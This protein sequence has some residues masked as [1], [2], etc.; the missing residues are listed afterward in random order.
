[1]NLTG[2]VVA[3][4]A[5][6]AI[7]AGKN[8]LV[9]KGKQTLTN[10]L[11]VKGGELFF[12]RK[13]GE[14]G[15]LDGNKVD[16]RGIP[17]YVAPRPTGIVKLFCGGSVIDG[18]NLNDLLRDQ[19][20]KKFHE[21]IEGACLQKA[22]LPEV[23]R[24]EDGEVKERNAPDAEPA[25]D[26]GEGMP[27]AGPSPEDAKVS[28]TVNRPIKI[29]DFRSMVT[30][31]DANM[32]RA[33]NRGYVRFVKTDGGEGVKLGK[34][35]NVFDKLMSW[36][37][38]VTK[39]HNRQM[40][41]LFAE[42]MLAD[43]GGLDCVGNAAADNSAYGS[44][45]ANTLS[46]IRTTILNS[47]D[48]GAM[49]KRSDMRKCFDLYDSIFGQESLLKIADSFLGE[50]LDQCQFVDGSG[51]KP[52]LET[53][54]KEYGKY[55]PEG[56]R[57][58]GELK[59]LLTDKEVKDGKSLKLMMAAIADAFGQMNSVW[60]QDKA[61]KGYLDTLAKDPMSA[62][63]LKGNEKQL[64]RLRGALLRR[65]PADGKVASVDGETLNLFFDK[66]FPVLEK[67]ARR[68]FMEN[69]DCD[70]QKFAEVKESRADNPG[71]LETLLKD[72]GGN[73]DKLSFA[74]EMFARRLSLEGIAEALNDF[75]SSMRERL[76]PNN[77]KDL[78]PI[79][80]VI[81]CKQEDKQTLKAKLESHIRESGNAD[82]EDQTTRELTGQIEVIDK[83]IAWLNE[84]KQ[85]FG[86]DGS[87]ELSED[88][89][90]TMS[91]GA[92][93]DDTLAEDGSPAR[94]RA[95][96]PEALRKVVE[97]GVKSLDETFQCNYAIQ[98]YLRNDKRYENVADEIDLD[99][100]AIMRKITEAFD[101]N[102]ARALVPNVRNEDD[103]GMND[104]IVKISDFLL[105]D[106][107]LSGL[108]NNEVERTDMNPEASPVNAVRTSL[109]T[110]IN[111]MM[112]AVVNKAIDR[113]L[114][115]NTRFAD[116]I[117][118][119]KS[120]IEVVVDQLTALFEKVK[121]G[122]LNGIAKFA[123]DAKLFAMKGA[124]D[125][126]ESV[127]KANQY[128]ENVQREIRLKMLVPFIEEDISD[129]LVETDVKKFAAA[130]QARLELRVQE[131]LASLLSANV[132]QFYEGTLHF[133][134]QVDMTAD[135]VRS[136][137]AAAEKDLKT[138]YTDP[139]QVA[140]TFAKA[141]GEFNVK[142]V[143]EGLDSSR[144]SF[145]PLDGDELVGVVLR[146]AED[147][148]RQ[149]VFSNAPG[150]HSL[151]FV[152]KLISIAQDFLSV[153]R[154]N[155]MV[156]IGEDKWLER[157][158]AKFKKRMDA[159]VGRYVAFERRLVKICRNEVSKALVASGDARFAAVVD[160][161]RRERLLNGVMG[162][163]TDRI[164]GLLARFVEMPDAFAKAGVDN[165]GLFGSDARLAEMARD[166][167]G[168]SVR[169]NVTDVRNTAGF[170]NIVGALDA[171]FENCNGFIKDRL[172]N[173]AK[174]REGIEAGVQCAV[175]EAKLGVFK[176]LKDG[177]EEWKLAAY[178]KAMEWAVERACAYARS[179]PLEAWD[180]DA[181]A[182]YR[183]L[184]EKALSELEVISGH[185]KQQVAAMN[186][187]LE[188]ICA[189]SE[190]KGDDGKAF[191][192]FLAQERN[193]TFAGFV[194]TLCDYAVSPLGKNENLKSRF[195][196]LV[197]STADQFKASVA[198]GDDRDVKIRT[199]FYSAVRP[200][201]DQAVQEATKK[202]Q[203]HGAVADVLEL[204]NERAKKIWAS[205]PGRLNEAV[206]T[207]DLDAYHT[208]N[209]YIGIGKSINDEIAKLA[210]DYASKLDAAEANFTVQGLEAAL[211]L[212]GVKRENFAD[213]NAF[214]AALEAVHGDAD[215]E[216][217]YILG[218]QRVLDGIKT[219]IRDMTFFNSTLMRLFD[220]H[221]RVQ[222]AKGNMEAVKDAV[223][224]RFNQMIVEEVASSEIVNRVQLEFMG[225][226]ADLDALLS[227]EIS[228]DAAEI[229]TLE[230]R[231]SSK[232]IELDGK[233]VVEK[234]Q[235]EVERRVWFAANL[236]KITARATVG[237]AE[238][239][240][241][242][243]HADVEMKSVARRLRAELQDFIMEQLSGTVMKEGGKADWDKALDG[244]LQ[245][246]DGVALSD[247]EGKLISTELQNRI[248]KSALDF[249]VAK[250][251]RIAER[252]I[253]D[254]LAAVDV[255]F[256]RS[257]LTDY[258]SGLLEA[259]RK[260][261]YLGLVTI[262]SK[263]SDPENVFRA[264]EGKCRKLAAIEDKQERQAV[265][266][267]IGKNKAI[268]DLD[269]LR[270]V[271][272]TL[273][274]ARTA[275]L[276][277]L[278]KAKTE[279][280]SPGNNQGKWY[281]KPDSNAADKDSVNMLAFVRKEFAKAKVNDGL[282]TDMLNHMRHPA[283]W[284]KLDALKG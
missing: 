167:L 4:G 284:S 116:Q 34:V 121:K 271:M 210:D 252:A 163:Y 80:A 113:K 270:A 174:I 225:Q 47:N 35:G 18:D 223:R 54:L 70:P 103:Y 176:A 211:A 150:R 196:K 251:K 56:M 41:L 175:G 72:A 85:R 86:K 166:L 94:N 206:K 57:T 39:E 227:Q 258:E 59:A 170:A 213:Q 53:F 75:A 199:E 179:N 74:R 66:V 101:G 22:A 105:F 202:L 132:R 55:A 11:K 32:P 266:A 112:K 220:I 119:V 134:T 133:G 143:F 149:E 165:Y 43:F 87:G 79:D 156:D 129:L 15:E 71:S 153:S 221:Y 195:G 275:Y 277:G 193:G 97:E 162:T 255:A 124:V 182:F 37:V 215:V 135:A 263:F 17:M 274:K 51:R 27:E 151:F 138:G 172:R 242:Q 117:D 130:A 201:Y 208:C 95:W 204:V 200:V 24:D 232:A 246:E 222:A 261:E 131:A 160:P 218:Q 205:L 228:L 61:V 276:E 84:Q 189:A 148:W 23:A 207:L 259:K 247:A 120:Q 46:T 264:F 123:Q 145:R 98:C 230:K 93:A 100:K 118:S 21:D 44:E 257:L 272:E 136:Q 239:F 114:E 229:E 279:A 82:L 73:A 77:R 141:L 104:Y 31:E 231:F 194:T 267:A 19:A 146:H 147:L 48:P 7:E 198:D 33:K 244:I 281:Y 168:L 69:C 99:V 76:D 161:A 127:A 12:G 142:E 102:V 256:C 241:E 159:F 29:E 214:N 108:K 64:G 171:T 78:T 30:F 212:A 42:T 190:K 155:R 107:K 238:V 233:E 273:K 96:S 5:K 49:L 249:Q 3:W 185:F 268:P 169:G 191:N 122:E 245:Q 254:D 92:L 203:E 217:F 9:N 26:D 38:N 60:Q 28:K 240:N 154:E 25:P 52:S 109:S 158:E 164:K 216:N 45:L 83:D 115:S 67:S 6:K 91:D 269:K 243:L 68:Q 250:E 236:E 180:D 157:R 187:E 209:A 140:Q 183:R 234:W 81:A 253:E 110:V 152:D 10:T 226:I 13:L 63:N 40:R 282:F 178:D 62:I 139:G 248:Q 50:C 20:I 265:A 90:K 181:D 186:G 106:V 283:W 144:A 177:D 58:V 197:V 260:Q 16:F 192:D 280:A 173:P 126:V 88:L 111:S 2:V 8:A 14:A 188:K 125:N 224:D 1:M 219:K 89:K 36:R 237:Y 184:A 262:D 128:L 278:R 137:F 65:M 235:K